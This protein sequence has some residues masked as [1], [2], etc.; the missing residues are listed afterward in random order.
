MQST[1][2]AMPPRA[3][4]LAIAIGLFGLLATGCGSRLKAPIMQ[5][6]RLAVKSVRITGAGVEVG[7]RIR[8]PNPETLEIE[9]FEYTLSLNGHKLGNGYHPAGMSLPGFGETMIETRFDLNFLSLPG[10][11]KAILDSDVVDAEAKG[12]FHIHNGRPLAFRA[13]GRVPLNR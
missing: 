8:N 11:V 2:N 3:A 7:F 6:E 9:R 5:V 13:T 1:G 10:T 12:K 4:L